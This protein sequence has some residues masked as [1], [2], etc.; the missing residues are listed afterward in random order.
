MPTRH[1]RS[2]G[3][4]SLAPP[5]SPYPQQI[6]PS[7][8]DSNGTEGTE[9]D[10]DVQE[11]A[12]SK[13]LGTAMSHGNFEVQSPDIKI[14]SPSSVKSVRHARCDWRLDADNNRTIHP[15]LT[16]S[17]PCINNLSLPTMT[18]SQ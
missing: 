4:D 9:I 3:N 7:P 8:V 12:E 15:E 17:Y 13:S 5:P 6:E 2:S 18:L 10:E 11:D 16:L 1:D 14:T